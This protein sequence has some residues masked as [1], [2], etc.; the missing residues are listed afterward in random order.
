MKRVGLAAL[1]PL[2]AL[3]PLAALAAGA[4]PVDR[5]ADVIVARSRIEARGRS[6][7]EVRLVRRGAT[8]VVQTL[9]ITRTLKRAAGRIREK[10][11]A[12]WP[13]GSR[14]YGASQVYAKALEAAV[15]QVLAAERSDRHRRL[16]IEIALSD[17]AGYIVLSKPSTQDGPDGIALV[18][19]QLITR[20]EL[21]CSWTRR[22]I[23]LVAEDRGL[24]VQEL[25]PLP[26]CAAP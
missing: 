13:E 10:E 9:L 26:A 3:L 1:L 7:G 6:H 25:A 19:S 24:D 22:E 23:E 15:A 20:L 18:A 16:L 14:G 5:S 21:P 2:T 11:E 12:N 8:A 17:N 4:D